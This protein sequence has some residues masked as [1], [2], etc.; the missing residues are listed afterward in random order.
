MG[1]K[2]LAAQTRLFKN[3]FVCKACGQKLR[4][5]S[6]RVIAKKVKCRRCGK[7]DFRPIKAKKK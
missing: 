2:I 7:K 1:T 6:I 5:D 4:T 3:I